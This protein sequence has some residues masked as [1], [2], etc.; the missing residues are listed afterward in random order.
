[1]TEVLK[2]KLIQ[3]VSAEPDID[4]KNA[5]FCVFFELQRDLALK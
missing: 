3:V 2:G 5:G 4:Y 1:M